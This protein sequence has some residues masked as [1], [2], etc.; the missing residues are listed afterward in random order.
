MSAW[1]VAA[2]ICTVALALSGVTLVRGDID[3]RLVALPMTSSIAVLDALAIAQ[4]FGN[5]AAFDVAALAALLSL[6]AGFVYAKF[7]G[8][9]L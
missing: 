8:R 5:E 2:L 9:W 1:T 3:T 4:S 6:P 7:Y